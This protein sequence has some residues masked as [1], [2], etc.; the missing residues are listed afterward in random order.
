LREFFG[1]ELNIFLINTGIEKRLAMHPDTF[2]LVMGRVGVV[3]T[4]GV[5]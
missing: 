3:N 4:G 2:K 5:G 1:E